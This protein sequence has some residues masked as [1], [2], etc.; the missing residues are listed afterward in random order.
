[1]LVTDKTYLDYFKSASRNID[2]ASVRFY[3]DNSGSNYLNVNNY[4]NLVSIK[5][6]STTPEGK[7]FGFAFSK[8]ITVELLGKLKH[9]DSN[10]IINCPLEGQRM[11]VT[12]GSSHITSTATLPF[13][14]IHTIAYDD[15]KNT[16]TITGYDCLYKAYK[17]I[18]SDVKITYPT[19]VASFVRKS[20]QTFGGNYSAF[21]LP[22][23]NGTLQNGPGF[24]GNESLF[25]ALGAVAEFTGT[26]C[27]VNYDDRVVF[28]QPAK[29]AL[30]S[31]DASAYFEM[32]TSHEGN[33]LTGLYTTNNLGDTSNQGTA[34][35]FTQVFRENA[36]FSLYSGNDLQSALGNVYNAVKNT[37]ATEYSLSWRGCP[38]YE[39]GDCIAITTT[40]GQVK[41][42]TYMNEVLT[43]DG[44]LKASAS[45]KNTE[46]VENPKST[47][48]KISDA[49]RQTT[50]KV[51]KAN[52]TITLL[53]ETADQTNNKLSQLELSN[54]N[55]T[56][57][58]ATLTEKVEA[59]M[60]A[61][62]V[63][64]EINKALEEGVNVDVTEVTTTTGFTFNEVGLTVD[65]SNSEL[66][67][68]ITEDGM[69]I[70]KSGDVVLTAD[71]I[72]VKA[73]NLHATTYLIIGANSRLEDYNNNRTGCYWVGSE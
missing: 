37:Y 39:I 50:A 2:V 46:V 54:N 48:N 12:I 52:Q 40:K 1:M 57:E 30:D 35:G 56:A 31:L 17:Y 23:N 21:S 61:D 13:F 45:W 8:K 66:S 28:R 44:G 9:F 51:D 27:Y 14:Y 32:T 20:I 64:I 55:I 41:Y 53:V 70:K 18:V 6:E 47:T 62:E 69:F 73:A 68:T 33:K 16:T 59:T 26:I 15:D 65:K 72:G 71:H 3:L 58:V 7:L 42:I 22:I 19:N 25:Y 34:E 67:T 43:Y 63:K 10:G 60:T 36:F 11:K 5:I 38:G 4:D 49:V 24:N 29:T